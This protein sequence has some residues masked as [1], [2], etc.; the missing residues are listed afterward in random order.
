MNTGKVDI[1]FFEKPQS[2]RER[3]AF[4]KFFYNT[5]PEVGTA[6]DEISFKKFKF[7]DID[8]TWGS[9][10]LR[11]YVY[12]FFNKMCERLN[13]ID[14]INQIS[15]EYFVM[16][17]GVVFVEDNDLPKDIKKNEFDSKLTYQGWK[18]L[19]LLPPDQ[20]RVRKIPLSEDII[21]SYIP[22]S[23]TLCFLKKRKNCFKFLNG[24]N[25]APLNQDPNSGSFAHLFARK[26]SQYDTLGISVIEKY[27]NDLVEKKK[28]ELKIFETENDLLNRKIKKFIEEC[29]FRPVAIKKGF[30]GPKGLNF[31]V[32]YPE[33]IL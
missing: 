8:D 21:L 7:G 13:I 30:V 15:H 19:L 23:K 5:V 4:Y 18:K 6:I 12:K 32:L 28:I 2:L 20:V 16:G 24:K 31:P 22:D 33:V 29:L 26:I 3:R 1:D 27:I 11:F 14:F 9:P 10:G 25:E 17:N